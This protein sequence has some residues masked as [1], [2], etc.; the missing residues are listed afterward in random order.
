MKD[1]NR[2][3]KFIDK[4]IKK[5]PT[6]SGCGTFEIL[7]VIF[8]ESPSS[9]SSL[10]I[11]LHTAEPSEYQTQFEATYA[12]YSRQ[13]IERSPEGWTVEDTRAYNNARVEFPRCTGLKNKITHMSVGTTAACDSKILFSI[14][15]DRPWLVTDGVTF[16]LPSGGLEI[17]LS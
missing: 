5:T 17:K 2:Y 16:T 14:E 7:N 1:R 9:P 10:W 6:P 13:A 3:K 11:A 4:W 12:S 8:E 15:L